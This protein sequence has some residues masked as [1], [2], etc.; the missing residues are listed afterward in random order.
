MDRSGL[1]LGARARLPGSE[2]DILDGAALS[3]PFRESSTA[4]PT[5]GMCATTPFVLFENIHNDAI[6][7]P[8]D[9]NLGG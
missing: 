4:H 3:R 6:L 8:A 9:R 2:W 7:E 1:H 5:L